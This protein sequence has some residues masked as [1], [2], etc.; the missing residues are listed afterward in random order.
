MIPKLKRFEV[1]VLL[2][3]GHPQEEVAEFTG[4]SERSVRRIAAEEPVSEATAGGFEDRRGAGRPGRAAAFEDMVREELE[5]EPGLKS[6][7][8]LRRA[9]LKGY[10]GRKSAFYEMVC[11]VRPSQSE[12]LMRLEGLPAEFSRHDFGRSTSSSWTAT[13]SGFISSPHA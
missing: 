4:V 8:L 9:K 2:H 10:T 13:E 11:P 7:E 5:R 1:Q 6:L 3:A 12:L